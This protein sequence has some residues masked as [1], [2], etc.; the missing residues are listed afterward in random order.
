M[1][2]ES[3][4]RIKILDYIRQ[5]SFDND[6]KITKSDVMKHLKDSRMMT[7]HK[8]TNELIKEGKIKMEKPKDK[9]Y[10]KIDYLTVNEEN[11]FNK[12]FNSLSVIESLINKMYNIGPIS[13]E[14]LTNL[15]SIYIVSIR[16]LL[17]FLLVR[18]EDKIHSEKDLLI[19]HKRTLKLME[20]INNLPLY[21]RNRSWETEIMD[22]IN[23]MLELK[24]DLKH[25][26]KKINPDIEESFDYLINELEKFKKKFLTESREKSSEIDQPKID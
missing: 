22:G 10:S 8:T 21:L 11:E 15:I 2:S 25:E 9:P 24:F 12:I 14:L 6:S 20:R 26:R 19:L 5:N 13:K 7:T 17:D 23:K 4:R 3:E 18:I 1:L 16:T